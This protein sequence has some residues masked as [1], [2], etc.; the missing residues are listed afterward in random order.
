MSL[1]KLVLKTKH[2][3]AM[4]ACQK[5]NFVCGKKYRLSQVFAVFII[6]NKRFFN[7]KAALVAV[8]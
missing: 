4:K 6:L 8:R 3:V 5:K 1:L 7:S 2:T